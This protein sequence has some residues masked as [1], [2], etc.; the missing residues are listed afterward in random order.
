MLVSRP[1]FRGV[2][3]VKLGP[4]KRTPCKAPRAVSCRE[5]R[6]GLKD[7][8][9]IRGIGFDQLRTKRP[10]AEG[11]RDA[12]PACGKADHRG[13]ADSISAPGNATGSTTG[14]ESGPGG[15][16]FREL[17]FH[18]SRPGGGFSAEECRA[19]PVRGAGVE[20]LAVVRCINFR[21]RG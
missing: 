17:F 21:P 3:S 10:A 19:E 4:W 11:A 5:L 20:I 1:L 12:P 8:L 15:A 7:R 18:A 13:P 14:P 16:N 6:P 2:K 9:S